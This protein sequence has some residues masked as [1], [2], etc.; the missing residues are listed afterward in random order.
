[1][2]IPDEA[3]NSA[4]LARSCRT[5][6]VCGL[7]VPHLR[8]LAAGLDGLTDQQKRQRHSPG[9]S[10][11]SQWRSLPFAG[12]VKHHNFADLRGM[13]GAVIGTVLIKCRCLV[14]AA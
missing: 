13:C 11:T 14:P 6:S 7:G 9:L 4:W 8:G 2:Y 12:C 1:M 3:C 10:I 5:V